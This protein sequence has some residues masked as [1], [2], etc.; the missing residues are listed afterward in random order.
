[1]WVVR[2]AH[3]TVNRF[4]LISDGTHVG[5]EKRAAAQAAAWDTE[6]RET[7][8]SAA[9][10]ARGEK[11]GLNPRAMKQLLSAE[12]RQRQLAEQLTSQVQDEMAALASIL[13]QGTFL[14][15]KAE[16]WCGP[17]PV[18]PEAEPLPEE[19]NRES[20]APRPSIAAKLIPGRRKERDA[21]AARRFADAHAEWESLKAA[22]EK[23]NREG[24]EKYRRELSSWQTRQK[25]FAESWKRRD[26]GVVRAYCEAI[27]KVSPYPCVSAS[28]AEIA[29]RHQVNF[30]VLPSE[31]LDTFPH[32][33]ELDYAAHTGTVVVDYELP[34]KEVMP[35]TK[36]YKYVATGDKVIPVPMPRASVDQ[37]YESVLYQIALRTIYELFRSD[38]ASA[39]D[40]VVF[41]GWV[42]ALDMQQVVGRTCASSRSRQARKSSSKSILPMLTRKPASG[43]SR[44]FPEQSLQRFLRSGRSCK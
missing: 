18:S 21:E 6:F 34:T 11:R 15:Y 4:R 35:S 26:Q 8:N 19:P 40:Y 2:L 43:S 44:E 25:E 42:S 7:I 5:A 36:G 22:V 37:T 16:F 1:M 23:R 27:L 28:I 33:F 10:V 20:Y 12:H 38:E 41:N 30:L 9:A 13:R 39:V 32:A 3:P 29:V 31:H 17:R 14:S 24:E